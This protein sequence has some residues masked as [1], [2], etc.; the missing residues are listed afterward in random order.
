[1]STILKNCIVKNAAFNSFLSPLALNP[2]AAFIENS[3]KYS[4]SSNGDRI[5]TQTDDAGT[6]GIPELAVGTTSYRTV[7]ETSPL[8]LSSYSVG[9]ND[10][11]NYAASNSAYNFLHNGSDAAFI[12]IF[13]LAFPATAQVDGLFSTVR[14]SV[15]DPGM[16]I[17][18]NS[19]R[20][21]QVYIR[22]DTSIIYNQI[23]TPNNIT[24]W[25]VISG[26]LT[27]STIKIYDGLNLKLDASGITGHTTNNAGSN[28]QIWGQ[29]GAANLD[30][31]GRALYLYDYLPDEKEFTNV[32]QGLLA[33]SAED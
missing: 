4:R 12:A 8:N 24:D 28:L 29:T 15:A 30:G 22:N 27:S 23:F 25:L 20:Q 33:N 2:A 9:D 11:K 18:I 7:V 16:G 26:R 13:K 31:W 19:S 21:V 1:M 3:A 17:I 6:V 5:H 10:Y 32:L 14:V